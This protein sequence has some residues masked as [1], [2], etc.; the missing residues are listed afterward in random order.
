MTKKVVKVQGFE[1]PI[2]YYDGDDCPEPF[3]PKRSTVRKMLK[4][5]KIETEQWFEEMD[6]LIYEKQ[7]V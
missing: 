4:Q 5:I 6:Q 2:L 1:L 3:V 7:E